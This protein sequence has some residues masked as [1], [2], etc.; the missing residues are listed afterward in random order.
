MRLDKTICE[1]YEKQKS[2]FLILLFS[3]NFQTKFLNFFVNNFPSRNRHVSD[4]T[5]LQYPP[6][7]FHPPTSWH[8][9]FCYQATSFSPSALLIFLTER[10]SS[11]PIPSRTIFKIF[12]K[13]TSKKLLGKFFEFNSIRKKTF[14]LQMTH[15]LFYRVFPHRPLFFFF[16]F[17]S[18]LND[19]F[20]AFA[21][22]S[23]LSRGLFSAHGNISAIPVNWLPFRWFFE[24][25][26]G[27]S[28]HLKHPFPMPHG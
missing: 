21:E 13:K 9:I 6:S 22:L 4:W 26:R 1:S 10:Y 16:F 24:K 19:T 3:K 25:I 15:I 14:L 7:S 27:V 18:Q 5:T 8:L 23:A 20:F 11:P 28:F 12:D 2:F 17:F